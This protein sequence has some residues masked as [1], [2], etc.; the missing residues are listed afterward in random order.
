[1]AAPRG[2]VHLDWR[3][4]VPAPGGNAGVVARHVDLR[5]YTV[6]FALRGPLSDSGMARGWG[7]SVHRSDQPAERVVHHHPGGWQSP[8][9]FVQVL[10][11]KVLLVV[12]MVLVQAMHHFAVQPR[13]VALL[14]HVSPTVPELPPALLRLQRVA[15][16]LR[17]L[18]LSLAA[19]ILGCA[20]LLH[21]V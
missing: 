13:G 1:M 16:G 12:G 18:M 11:I 17:L 8:S 9:K 10:S 21:G 6:G 19:L 2:S 20:L 3:S 14:R 15:L 4:G 7:R 5:L